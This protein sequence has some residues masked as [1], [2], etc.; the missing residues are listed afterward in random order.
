MD[1]E[2]D[3]DRSDLIV[4]LLGYYLSTY[5]LFICNVSQMRAQRFVGF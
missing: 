5:A 3:I 2:G 1:V 4:T